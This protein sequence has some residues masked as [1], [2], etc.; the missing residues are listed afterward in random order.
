[1]L[2]LEVL[3][4]DVDAD[5]VGL[6]QAV[7]RLPVTRHELLYDAPFLL[8]KTAVDCH[9]RHRK[10]ALHI[11]QMGENV[12]P[13]LLRLNSVSTTKLRRDFDWR[14]QSVDRRCRRCGLKSPTDEGSP[15]RLEPRP[16]PARWILRSSRFRFFFP[17]AWKDD[18]SPFASPD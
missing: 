16:R 3:F 17:Q 6:D 8:Q 1:I 18:R 7:N 12:E 2:Q 10:S 15:I 13:Q 14:G 5:L 11:A 4:I 9:D